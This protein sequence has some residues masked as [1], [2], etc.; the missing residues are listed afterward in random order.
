MPFSA[1]MDDDQRVLSIQYHG[2]MTLE[3]R[4]AVKQHCINARV[5]WGVTRYLIDSRNIEQDIDAVNFAQYAYSFQR[6]DFPAQT[7]LALV[8]SGNNAS[9][10]LAKTIIASRGITIEA[11][12]D[13]QMAWEWLMEGLEANRHNTRC[14]G[15]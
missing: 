1:S 13:S 3:E 2:D 10:N 8:I 4:E 5:D 9:L 11:F 15:Y 14:A 6:T 7:K 12:S